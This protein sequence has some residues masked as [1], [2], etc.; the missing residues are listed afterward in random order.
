MALSKER[1]QDK[2]EIVGEHKHI[3]VRF[4]EKI[5]EDGEVISEIFHRD[6][7]ICGD[8]DKADAL[9]V[10]KVADASWTAAL[11]KS[12]KASQKI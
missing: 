8:Y 4:V 12:Y 5:I 6:V 9:E 3:Q 7:A 1:V 11:V 2:V 10:R